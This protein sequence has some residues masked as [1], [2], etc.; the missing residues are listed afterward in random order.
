M[1]M[2]GPPTRDADHHG[3]DTM[4]SLFVGEGASV[5]IGGERG[6]HDSNACATASC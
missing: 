2:S 1:K 5:A 3:G 4:T 6:A